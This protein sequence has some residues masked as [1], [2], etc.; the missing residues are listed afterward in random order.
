MTRETRQE[1]FKRL[2]TCRVNGILEKLR[3][4]GNLSNRANYSWEMKDIKKIFKAIETRTEDTRLRFQKGNFTPFFFSDGS[5]HRG[6]AKTKALPIKKLS[7]KIHKAPVSIKAPEKK[8]E[9]RVCSN[10]FTNRLC[11]KYGS[12]KVWLCVRHCWRKRKI[13]KK[14]RTINGEARSLVI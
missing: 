9:V 11:R 8:E 12:G 10:C 7:K 13:I 1:R 2:A 4:F 6:K 5:P 3:I 14:V